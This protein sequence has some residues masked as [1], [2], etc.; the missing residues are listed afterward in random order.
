MTVYVDDLRAWGWVLYGRQV[1]SCHMTSDGLQLDELHAMAARIGLQ[2]RWF[3]PGRAGRC[4]HYDLTASR[5]EAAV[6]AGAVEI[7]SKQ[8]VLIQRERHQRLAMAREELR[9]A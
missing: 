6:A 9:R 1:D 2:R 5:R 8:L 3:Q 4:P 7:S